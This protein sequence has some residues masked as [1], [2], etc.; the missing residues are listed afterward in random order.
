[1][2][3]QRGADAERDHR[4]LVPRAQAHQIGHVLRAFGEHHGRGRRHGGEG[5]FVAA[6][7]LA[8]RLC[9][10]ELR[11]EAAFQAV[12]QRR[13]HGARLD[14]G[15]DVAGGGGGVHGRALLW[16]SVQCKPLPDMSRSGQT[17][18]KS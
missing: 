12:D 15:Q 8:H 17:L 14:Y 10:G 16:L 18:S 4:H 3:F 7:L 9:V 5:R 13:R 11:A 2:P 6:V 1:M